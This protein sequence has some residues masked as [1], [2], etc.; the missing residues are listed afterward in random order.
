MKIL[1]IAAVGFLMTVAASASTLLI[2]CGSGGGGGWSFSANTGTFTS[3]SP[4]NSGSIT[5]PAYSA[6]PAGDFFTSEQL[7]IQTDYTGGSLGSTNTIQTVYSADSANPG[8]F[9][10]DVLT[11][12]SSP[13]TGPSETY[14][15]ANSNP[16]YTPGGASYFLVNTTLSSYPT[17]PFIVDF[18]SAVTQGSVQGESGQVYE[19]ITYSSAVPEPG[20]MM[21]MGSGLVAFA[22]IGRKLVRK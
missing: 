3:S 17:S 20:S 9:T 1:N 18:S 14:T 6:L 10:G 21:L 2:A 15:S 16:V 4:A 5:C 7:V 11:S 8:V 22:L 19:L 13:G 12:T